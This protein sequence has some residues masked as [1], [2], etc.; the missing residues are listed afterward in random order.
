MPWN[1]RD[2]GNLA[3]VAFVVN[4]LGAT[5]GHC[6]DDGCSADFPEWL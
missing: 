2:R 3:L 4:V 5:G 6:D 1:V